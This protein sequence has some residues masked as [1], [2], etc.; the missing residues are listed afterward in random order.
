MS[1]R[2]TRFDEVMEGTIRLAGEDRDRPLRLELAADLPGVLTP[3]S[4]VEG[5][6]AGRVRVPGWADDRAAR[7]TLRVAPIAARR[8]RYTLDF[9]TG[10]GRS[11]RLDGLKSTSARHPVRSMTRLP[12]TV[13]DAEG[14]VVGQARLRFAVRRDLARFLAGFRFPGHE[15]DLMASRWRGQPG[16]LE[17]WYTTLTDPATGT[18][19]WLHHEL[20]APAG[21]GAHR[22]HGWAAVFPPDGAPVFGRFASYDDRFTGTADGISWELAETGG[23]RPM[24]TFPRWAWERELLPAAQV[25]PKPAAVYDGTVRFGGRTLELRGARG[26]SAH[27]YG[28]GNAKRW[29]WLHADLGGG[30]VCEVVAAVSTR[31]VL[32][33]LPALPL[34]RLRVGGRDWPAGDPLLA[35]LRLRADLGL[36]TWTVR[37]R[38]GDRRLVVR[39]TQPPE[40]TVSVDYADP[41]GAPAVCHNTERADVSI[42]LSRRDGGRW[43]TEREWTLRGTGHAELG[44]R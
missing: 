17:V 23:G 13:T 29:V 15:A 14:T 37:G 36:P 11:L 24:F 43:R 25:V 28:H 20:V 27:I 30:D 40:E 21:G 32:D 39:V 3:W 26:A 41:D 16:R 38:I 12:A 4:D 10:D 1:G 18:G 42:V 5:A 44:E 34:V 7:G 9:A 2:R 22:R 19:L 33:R 6:L 35:A 8:I 31:P